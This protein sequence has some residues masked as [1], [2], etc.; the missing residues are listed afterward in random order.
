MTWHPRSIPA[1]HLKPAGLK[2]DSMR[3]V[4]RNKIIRIS[5]VEFIRT[6][7]AFSLAKGSSWR[8]QCGWVVRAVDLKSGNP[9]F[10]CCSDHKLDLFQV[11]SDSN[12]WLCSYKANWSAS[13]EIEFTYSVHL[14][15]SVAICTAHDGQ[16][17]T[18][19]SDRVLLLLLLCD[20][21]QFSGV[22][23]GLLSYV[24]A[25]SGCLEAQHF[26]Q[27]VSSPKDGWQHCPSKKSDKLKFP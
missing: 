4:E 23:L 18:Y 13:C 8:R 25:T 9:E 6:V 26:P 5:P 3:S 19:S 27:D 10:K 24:L 21:L 11:V 22:I 1:G 2:S 17:L 12:P 16:L 15:Y 14:L 7:N 20:S